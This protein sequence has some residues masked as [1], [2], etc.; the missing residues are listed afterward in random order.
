MTQ[1]NSMEKQHYKKQF[2]N[3]L[4]TQNNNSMEKQIYKKQFVNE[5]MT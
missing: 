5:L 2:V 4:M 1:N 3:E